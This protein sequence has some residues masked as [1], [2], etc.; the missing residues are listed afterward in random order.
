[1]IAICPNT[2]DQNRAPSLLLNAAFSNTPLLN[3]AHETRLATKPTSGT[4]VG[5]HRIEWVS[6]LRN[7]GEDV[8]I[9]YT[10]EEY[11]D[12]MGDQGWVFLGTVGGLEGLQV[13]VVFRYR[14]HEQCETCGGFPC[15]RCG[16]VA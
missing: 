15:S 6:L 8:G 10:F 4:V 14:G 2:H 1:V 11:L 12:H 5:E 16:K 7:K 13:R 3:E 9:G